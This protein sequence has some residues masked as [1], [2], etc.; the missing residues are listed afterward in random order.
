MTNA[1]DNIEIIFLKDPE[2]RTLREKKF[3]L[4]FLLKYVSFLK[5]I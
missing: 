1:I 3:V 4:E 2:E 5:D